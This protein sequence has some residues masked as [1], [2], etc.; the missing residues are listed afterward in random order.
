M[1]DP[2]IPF[3]IEY[4][5]GFVLNYLPERGNTGCYTLRL[6]PSTW[7]DDDFVQVEDENGNNNILVGPGNPS[8]SARICTKWVHISA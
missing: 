8:A 2:T 3:A 5:S 4:R 1:K 7:S 6:D